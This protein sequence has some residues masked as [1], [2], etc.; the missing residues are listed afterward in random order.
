MKKATSELIL[1]LETF[2]KGENQSL[3][4]ANKIEGFLIEHFP[5]D[6]DLDDLLL[7][8]ACY[9]PSGGEYLYD[10]ESMTKVVN[11]AIRVLRRREE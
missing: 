1:M 3:E 9:S 7:A 6:P 5:E 11:G 4:F 2:V 10:P 8:L